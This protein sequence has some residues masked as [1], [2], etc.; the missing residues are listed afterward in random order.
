[1][2]IKVECPGCGTTLS[3]ADKFAGKRGKCPKCKGA[4]DIPAAG[5]APAQQPAPSPAGAPQPATTEDGPKLCPKCDKACDAG[6]VICISCG[7]NF[8]TGGQLQTEIEEECGVNFSGRVKNKR[9]RKRAKLKKGFTLDKNFKALWDKIKHKTK[10]QVDY[11]TK[12]LIN[13][14]GKAI[15]GLKITS[16]SL[17]RRRAR[18]DITD[19][20]IESS[21]ISERSQ[22]V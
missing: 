9:N 2:S 21:I 12:V 8:K 15:A 7:Y 1:M 5:S 14:A 22:E 4:I 16:P 3:V 19:K 13:K 17:V 11:S 6:A 18:F 10:Y 20:G